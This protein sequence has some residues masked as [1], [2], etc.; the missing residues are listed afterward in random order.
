MV[1][2][3]SVES[4]VVLCGSGGLMWFCEVLMESDVVLCGS[5]WFWSDVVL[6]G[7]DGV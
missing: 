2:C 5:V 7:S 3:G 6:C 4:D 1:L